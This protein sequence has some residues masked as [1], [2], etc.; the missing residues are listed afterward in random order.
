MFCSLCGEKA[1]A[2]VAIVTTRWDKEQTDIAAARE[3]E[4]KD[5]SKFLKPALEKHARLFRHDNTRDSAIRIIRSVLTNTPIPLLI[6]Q[7]LIDLS[8]D[9]ADTTAGAKLCNHLLEEVEADAARLDELNAN[10]SDATK[11]GDDETRQELD[12]EREDVK[13]QMATIL[14]ETQRLASDYQLE[15]GKLRA[16]LRSRENS[17]LQ[18]STAIGFGKLIVEVVLA[19]NERMRVREMGELNLRMAQLNVQGIVD[20]HRIETTSATSQ[21]VIDIVKTVARH[22][23]P[24]FY[25]N[26]Y[27]A[28]RAAGFFL[29]CEN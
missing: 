11:E 3:E 7:E 5:D 23:L 9:L 25:P 22:A 20:L 1:L 27:Y 14:A 19:V 13:K 21:G 10:I 28:V 24:A 15:I 6:Q 26:Y 16:E 29:F 8:K 12:E 17:G 2:N 18:W 4:L